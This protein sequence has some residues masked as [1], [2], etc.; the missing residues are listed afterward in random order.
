MFVFIVPP[1]GQKTKGSMNM[2][3]LKAARK[4]RKKA[5]NSESKQSAP[6]EQETQK[7][8]GCCVVGPAC[9]LYQCSITSCLFLTPYPHRSRKL[10]QGEKSLIR[11]DLLENRLAILRQMIWVDAPLTVGYIL[12]SLL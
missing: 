2:K 1:P 10:L 7:N 3:E 8:G 12:R 11:L 5:G 6:S 4:N 9:A